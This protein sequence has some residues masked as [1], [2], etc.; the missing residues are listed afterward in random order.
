[1]LIAFVTP[2]VVALDMPRIVLLGYGDAVVSQPA[3][4]QVDDEL[5]PASVKLQIAFPDPLLLQ[6]KLAD[7]LREKKPV[8]IAFCYL[9]R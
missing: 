2:A 7:L 6:Q 8:V 1:L 3:G 4:F 5:H 9:L